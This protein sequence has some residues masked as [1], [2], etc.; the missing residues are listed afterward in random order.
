VKSPYLKESLVSMLCD[1][2]YDNL[3]Q[4]SSLVLVKKINQSVEMCMST[5]R[6]IREFGRSQP[7]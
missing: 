7:W 4:V 3:V 6:T 2:R 1:L 5:A